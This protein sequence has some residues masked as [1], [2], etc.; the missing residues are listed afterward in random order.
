[1]RNTV[2][3]TL[4]YKCKASF[5]SEAV[6]AASSATQAVGEDKDPLYTYV[7]HMS[8]DITYKTHRRPNTEVFSDY[9]TNN[10]LTDGN[11]NLAKQGLQEEV[12]LTQLIKISL[13]LIMATQEGQS[14][15]RRALWLPSPS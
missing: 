1:M 2:V 6:V 15:P 14:S 12:L 10:A 11:T 9:I 7:E 8:Q 3:K 13:A 4:G 5:K